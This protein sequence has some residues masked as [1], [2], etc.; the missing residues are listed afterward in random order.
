MHPIAAARIKRV[1]ASIFI[2]SA[3]TC[4]FV[5]LASRFN[6]TNL[7]KILLWP[8]PLIVNAIPGLN[9]GTPEN[10]IYEATP[11]HFLGYIAGVGVSAIFYSVVVYYAVVKRRFLNKGV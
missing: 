3:I 10:P 7:G 9:V 4:V 1:V 5:W 2:G 6:N 8:V 11:L